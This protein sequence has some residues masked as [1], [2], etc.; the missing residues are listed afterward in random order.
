MIDSSSIE[1]VKN[2]RVERIYELDRVFPAAKGCLLP[3]GM[4]LLGTKALH[5]QVKIGSLES[6]SIWARLDS[7]ADIML[8]S[9]EFWKSMVNTP[10]LREGMRMKLYHLTSGAKVLGYIKTELY[11]LAW[12]ESIVSF[13]LEAYMVWNMNVS[14]LLGEDFQ[15]TYELNV[16]RYASGHC[17]VAIGQSGCVISAASS[18]NIDLGFEIWVAHST[19]SFIWRKAVA[20]TKKKGSATKLME[21]VAW[22]MPSSNY[23]IRNVA[24]HAA[25]EGREDWIVEKVIIGTDD[26]DENISPVENLI[27]TILTKIHL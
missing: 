4:G 1:P 23:S 3:E 18:H 2:K 26:M 17:D 14:I 25:F 11:A 9:E 6:E 5:I 19:W 16:T 13:E 12:D 20:R 24:M 27:F 22:R 10:R 7:G 21:V 8:I 15:T